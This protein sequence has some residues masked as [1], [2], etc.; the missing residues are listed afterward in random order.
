MITDSSSEARRPVSRS[1]AFLF[2]ALAGAALVASVLALSGRS[3]QRDPRQADIEA[4]AEVDRIHVDVQQHEELE[5]RFVRLWG[6]DPQTV[7]DLQQ[8]KADAERWSEDAQQLAQRLPDMQS[9]ERR[10]AEVRSRAEPDS[11]SAR[12]EARQSLERLSGEMTAEREV[13]VDAAGYQFEARGDAALHRKL[14]ERLV[15]LRRMVREGEPGGLLASV[16][17]R[18]ARLPADIEA[19]AARSQAESEAEAALAA[20]RARAADARRIDVQLAKSEREKAWAHAI[21][22][23]AASDR[24]GGMKLRVHEG[25]VPIGMDPVSKLWEFV[26]LA[27]GA[28]G[29]EIPELDAATGRVAPSGDMG[30]VLV[31][32]P[33]GSFCMGAQHENA[34]KPNYDSWARDD[35]RPHQ[36]A[37]SPFFVGKHEVTQ[38]QWL[39][40][41]GQN[42][43]AGKD[44]GNLALPV[45]QVSWNDISAMTRQSGLLLPTEAQWEYA[46]RAGTTTPWWTGDDEVS[47][48]E[49]AVF[50]AAHAEPVGS[51]AAN[52][53]GL[54]DTAGNVSEWCLDTYEP[55]PLSDVVD[56]VVLGNPCPVRRGGCYYLSAGFCRSAIRS[57][58]FPSRSSEFLGFRVAL[59]PV[60]VQ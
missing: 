9:L 18:L 56:P 41:R 5:R 34:G 15:L 49:G 43:S 1:R 24:Y 20:A 27:S 55:Y 31:L 21:A 53:F 60:L 12:A 44:R 33:A 36:V 50:A 19:A 39:R 4:F 7:A 59:A 29:N 47:L 38:G 26:H 17:A 14:T 52:A 25:L 54:H 37:V 30:I 46:C 2:G 28:P 22:A 40:L 42:P 8:W 51:K 32:L 11:D 23:V 3:L 16:R 45:E 48:A 57:G 6:S 10:L 58:G 35:E 13:L